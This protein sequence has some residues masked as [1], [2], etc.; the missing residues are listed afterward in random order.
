MLTLSRVPLAR[1]GSFII[2]DG[3]FL[4]LINRPLTVEIQDLEN[5]GI[6]VD[7]PRDQT[8]ASVDLYVNNF[9]SCYDN[10]LRHELNAVNNV[11]DC[12]GQISALTFLKIMSRQFFTRSL[13]HGPFIFRLTDLHASNI[14][15]DK[16]WNVMRFIDLKWAASL[17]VEFLQIPFWL[18]SQNV[19]VIDTDAY[20][21]VREKFMG[22]FEKEEKKLHAGRN[23]QQISAIMRNG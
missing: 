6:L 1:I 22:I 14:F 15:V 18:I 5:E 19:N 7:I 17:P 10:R 20:N 12:M 13:N 9:L 11:P 21:I 3:G 23:G 2:D 16:D 8:Y 4:R